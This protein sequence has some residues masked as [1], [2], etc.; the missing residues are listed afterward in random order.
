MHR[1]AG[2][3]RSCPETSRRPGGPMPP[4]PSLRPDCAAFWLGR[5][6]ASGTSAGSTRPSPPSVGRWSW[7]LG[8][9]SPGR[10]W[11]C[12]GP[13]SRSGPGRGGGRPLWPPPA[14]R[15]R[16]AP[17]E[18]ADRSRSRMVSGPCRA[19][20]SRLPMCGRTTRRSAAWNS[21]TTSPLMYHRF[22]DLP[23]ALLHYD[24]LL[25][26]EPGH[27]KGRMNRAIV[28][29]RLGR[30][31]E[32]MAEY[33]VLADHPDIE[34]VRR[35]GADGDDVLRPALGRRRPPGRS[36]RGVPA[37]PTGGRPVRA[38]RPLPRRGAIRPGPC[39]GRR[40]PDR[41]LLPPPRGRCPAGG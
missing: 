39:P 29:Q 10:T 37:G 23:R 7:R 16:G 15:R 4:A 19:V 30:S 17:T 20:W 3:R 25:D 2:G 31:A 33:R 18:A 28:L 14:S 26:A 32:A 38:G 6:R 13:P 35:P 1:R 40:G 41:P 5:G 8:G 24:A 9:R 34:P 22:G 27:L 21:D 12:W 36:G 11:P